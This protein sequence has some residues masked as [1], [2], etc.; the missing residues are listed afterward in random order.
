MNSLI[1]YEGTHGL[2][3]RA[4]AELYAATASCLGR[5]GFTATP[6]E[7][8]LVLDLAADDDPA[9]EA[10]RAELAAAYGPYPEK[11]TGTGT[12]GRA[13]R[14]LL[15]RVPAD[16]IA[17]T[18]EQAAALRSR[19]GLLA[20]RAK[21]KL[22]WRFRLRDPDTRELLAGQDALPRLDRFPGGRGESSSVVLNLGRSASAD[23]WLLFPFEDPEGAFRAYVERLQAELSVPLAPR[24]WRQWRL[25]RAG[26]WKAA[27]LA[28]PPGAA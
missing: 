24:G 12:D 17:T 2:G 6:D 5:F 20:E 23:V 1:S 16:G 19:G 10:A 27:K 7:A 18:L 14:A 25:S 11:I 13:W 21:V 9:L 22:V 15:W 4:P 26:T 8:Y 3:R 28:S